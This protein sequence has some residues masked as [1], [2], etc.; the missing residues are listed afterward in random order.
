MKTF[1]TA[2]LCRITA[3][4]LLATLLLTNV[5]HAKLSANHNETEM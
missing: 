1:L 4:A 5:G 3:L 2:S